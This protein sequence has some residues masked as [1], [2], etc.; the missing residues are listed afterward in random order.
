MKRKTSS[1]TGKSNDI[2][3]R[4]E[5]GESIFIFYIYITGKD[6]FRD[7]LGKTV[8]ISLLLMNFKSRGV[9]QIVVAN[10]FIKNP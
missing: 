4:F 9:P 6:L 1:R 2:A 8:I 10:Y 7:A 5:A 3:S